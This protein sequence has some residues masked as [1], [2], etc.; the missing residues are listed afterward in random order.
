MDSGH[1]LG[2]MS[3]G[4]ALP[5]GQWEIVFKSDELR[6]GSKQRRKINCP[7]GET[8]RGARGEVLVSTS[9]T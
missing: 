6:I 3:L 8:G 9:S 5:S 4:V 7:A 2:T 1:L